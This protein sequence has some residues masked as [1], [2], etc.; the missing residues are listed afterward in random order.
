MLTDSQTIRRNAARVLRAE[1]A[2]NGWTREQ[3]AKRAGISVSSL[4][5]YEHA[6]RDMP[7][8]TACALADSYGVT[9]D[10]LARFD[11]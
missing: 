3:A 11:L 4:K 10:H 2:R 6:E 5:A 9:L 8:S 1:R 7:F